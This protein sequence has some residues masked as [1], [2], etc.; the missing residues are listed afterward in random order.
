VP[1]PIEED[2]VFWRELKCEERSCR[3]PLRVIAVR[4]IAMSNEEIAKD[5]AT[6][7]WDELRCPTGN[8]ILKIDNQH[9]E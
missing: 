4:R 1:Y 3:T 5:V 8:L 2:F 9:I 7:E 6:W